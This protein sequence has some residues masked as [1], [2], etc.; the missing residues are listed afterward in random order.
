MEQA[1]EGG[2]EAPIID[3]YIPMSAS[4][5]V[6]LQKEVKQLRGERIASE[7]LVERST[8]NY[9]HFCSTTSNVE[10]EI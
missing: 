2:E 3:Q 7:S 4:F 8:K 10:F 9:A 1:F 5:I 6:R